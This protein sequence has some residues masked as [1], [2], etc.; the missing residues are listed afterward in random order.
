MSHEETQRTIDHY[1]DPM[2]RGGDF[3]EC[4]TDGVTWSTLD[5]GDEVRGRSSVRDYIAALHNK[6]SDAQ[7]RRI[8]VSDG[9]G[10]LEG[11]CVQAPA[12]SGSR[13]FYCVAYD[14]VDGQITAMR[15]YGP[16]ADMAP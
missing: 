10:Y 4:Y 11:D 7:T 13:I 9:H 1:F 14:I 5:I 12:E 2:S 16:F 6:M 8:V 3:A 15:C